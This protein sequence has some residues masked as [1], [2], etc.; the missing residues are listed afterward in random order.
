MAAGGSFRF[1]NGVS[2][3][4]LGS[5]IA[6][7]AGLLYF[8][9]KQAGEH[10]H[11]EERE[12]VEGHLESPDGQQNELKKTSEENDPVLSQEFVEM[13]LG[14]LEQQEDILLLEKT[15][16]TIANSAA[17]T[18]NQVG[19]KVD[20]SLFIPHHPPPP[21][22]KSPVIFIAPARAEKTADE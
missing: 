18:Q 17:F 16:I 11:T 2:F 15:L 3:L 13:L 12:E 9:F 20:C 7:T 6:A 10:Q 21:P 8:L 19:T 22:F 1:S 4:C 5:L 14:I